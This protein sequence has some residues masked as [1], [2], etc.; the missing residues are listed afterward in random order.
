MRKRDE[1]RVRFDLVPNDPDWYPG[2]IRF[3]PSD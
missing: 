3:V 2:I 1:G